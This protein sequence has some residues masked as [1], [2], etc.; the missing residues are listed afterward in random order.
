MFRFNGFKLW[1]T[2][3]INLDKESSI[4]VKDTGTTVV[5]TVKQDALP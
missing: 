3:P 1:Q 5:P 4:S 2:S